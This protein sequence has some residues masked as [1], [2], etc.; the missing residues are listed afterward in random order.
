[1]PV[2]CVEEKP[3]VVQGALAEEDGLGL[4]LDELGEDWLGEY[5]D[6]GYIELLLKVLAQMCDGQFTGLQVVHY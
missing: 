2:D 3:D 6:E 1:M 5:K 4:E